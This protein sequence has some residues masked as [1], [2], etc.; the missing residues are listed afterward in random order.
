MKIT[1]LQGRLYAATIMLATVGSVLFGSATSAK[2]TPD[3]TLYTPPAPHNVTAT[4]SKNNI[5]LTWTPTL[6]GSFET[7]LYNQNTGFRIY[8]ATGG[9]FTNAALLATVSGTSTTFNDTSLS[10]STA[11]TYKVAALG[12]DNSESGNSN[13]VSVTSTADSVPTAADWWTGTVQNPTNLTATT[14]SPTSVRLTWNNPGQLDAIW[15]Y[16][17]TSGAPTYTDAIEVMSGSPTTYTSNNLQ[18]NTTYYFRVRTTR[19]W[20]EAPFSSAPVVSISTGNAPGSSATSSSA[21]SAG[22]VTNFKAAAIST[23]TITLGWPTIAGA[24]TIRLY[25]SAIGNDSFFL[26][27]TT[28]SGSLTSFTDTGLSPSTTYYYRLTSVVNGKETALNLA[29]TAFSTTLPAVTNNTTNGITNFSASSQTG[30]SILLSWNFTGNADSFHIFRNSYGSYGTFDSLTS[31]PGNARTYVDSNL[32]SGTTY[33]YRITVVANG[34][35][36]SLTSAP[37]TLSTAANDPSKLNTAYWLYNDYYYSTYPYTSTVYNPTVTYPSYVSNLTP[38]LAPNNRIKLSWT[39]NGPADRFVIYQS[40]DN[41]LYFTVGAVSGTSTSFTDQYLFPG[42]KYWYKV[43]SVKNNYEVPLSSLSPVNIVLPSAGTGGVAGSAPGTVS[44][45][46]QDDLLTPAY[47]TSPIKFSFTNTNGVLAAASTFRFRYQFTNTNTSKKSFLF[48]EEIISEFGSVLSASSNV[49]SLKGRSQL[50]APA[51]I[52]TLPLPTGLYTY[53]VSV[54]EIQGKNQAYIGENS[55][56][57][58]VQ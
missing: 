47:R 56:R 1:L 28:L 46:T 8:R 18:P 53:K 50:I 13:A 7:R 12:Y 16:R 45:N 44:G 24:E 27:L 30:R 34:N 15:I 36:T 31:V 51:T 29:A 5:A 33:Y 14:V 26:P 58:R 57:F 9:S 11:Y 6:S 25:R 54:R 32:L 52:A 35:E 42:S 43:A 17:S 37:T 21:G 49:S 2:E 19:G 48:K 40:S 20:L 3:A 23:S 38:S 55:F 41:L 22:P 39:V 10:A 4:V